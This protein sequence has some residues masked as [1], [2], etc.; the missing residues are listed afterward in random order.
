MLQQ[1]LAAPAGTGLIEIWAFH[2]SDF[3]LQYFL[4]YQ[5]ETLLNNPGILR[6]ASSRCGLPFL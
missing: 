5:S 1:C 6:V 2:N 4:Y 3:E